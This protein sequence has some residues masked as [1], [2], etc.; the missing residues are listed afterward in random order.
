MGKKLTYDEFINKAHIKERGL[1]VYGNYINSTTHIE[2]HCSFG[3]I[4]FPSPNNLMYDNSGCPHCLGKKA[5]RGETDLWTTRPDVA[6]LL[7][8]PEDGYKYTKGS[9]KKVYFVCPNCGAIYYKQID[10]VCRYGFFCERCSDGISYPNKFGRA[11]L[12]QLNC[13]DF[14][15]E[16]QPDWAKPYF[17]DNYFEYSGKK[18]ILEMDGAF[19]YQDLGFSH[20]SLDARKKNDAIKDSLATS[21]EIEIIRIDCRKS[22][23]DYIKNNILYS[24]LN[25]IFDLSCVNWELC[26]ANAQK[27]LIKDVCTL[28]NDGM[29]DLHDIKDKLHISLWAAQKYIKIGSNVGWCDYTIEKAKQIGINKRMVP[30]NVVDNFDNI[31]HQFEGVNVCARNMEDLYNIKFTTPNIIKSCKTYKPY[32]GFNFRYAQNINKIKM[33]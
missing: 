6:K 2:I 20:S 25:E 11:L 33:G 7:K 32:K 16:W 15:C 30:V 24:K 12:E 18:Y 31:I 23:L 8:N 19:H 27:N 29:Y 26:D 22:N 13:V 4:W 9:N 3:H 21:H 14:Q 5:W 28:Y 1:T 10:M 17:Y